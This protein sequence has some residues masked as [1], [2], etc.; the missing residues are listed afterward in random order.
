MISM[1]DEDQDFFTE[2]RLL[3]ALQI[4]DS[5]FPTGGFTQSYGLE[6]FVQDGTICSAVSFL[7][8]MKTYLVDVLG[9]V[10]CPALCLTHRYV[11]RG[12]FDMM[13]ELDQLLDACKTS[14]E[15]REASSRTGR[16]ML[17]TAGQ[18]FGNPTIE[19]YTGEVE[20]GTAH[21]HHAVVYGLIT[22]STGLSPLQ[23][24][25][26]FL[27]NAAAGMASAAIRLV[28]LGQRETQEVLRALH[29]AMIETAR[30]SLLLEMWDLGS[31]APALEIRCMAH[32]RLYTRLFMS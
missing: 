18:L 21:G 17:R 1:P 27:Y 14:R 23:S 30:R 26:V 10:D 20:R 6:T 8:F 4:A 32:E 25:L 22:W 31:F 19:K 12:E 29:P 9:R 2:E 16:A 13:L 15:A 5:L 24:N 28:P 7:E 11:T 3:I